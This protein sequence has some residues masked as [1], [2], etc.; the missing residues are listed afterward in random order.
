[1]SYLHASL[2]EGSLAVG[3]RVHPASSTARLAGPL[4]AAAVIL[5]LAQKPLRAH[6]GHEPLPTKGVSVQG[7]AIYLSPEASKALRLTFQEVDLADL[8]STVTA[9]ASVIVPWQQRAWVTTPT[10][11]RISKLYRRA[12]DQIDAG[13]VIAEVESLEL[14]NEQ[15]ELIQ[16]ALEL[17]LTEQTLERLGQLGDSGV[18]PERNVRSAKAMNAETT[19]AVEIGK[20]KLRAL[21]VTDEMLS[22]VLRSGEPIRRIPILAPVGGTIV[23][24][25]INPGQVV[26]PTQ[27]LFEILDLRR[28]YAEAWI[29]ESDVHRIQTGQTARF[30]MT[31][32]PDRAFEGTVDYVAMQA[33]GTSR[34]LKVWVALETVDA[35]NPLLRPGMFGSVQIVTD[36]AHDAIA[37]PASAFIR[38]GT[39]TVVF[40]EQAPGEY[41]RKPVVLGMRTPHLVEVVDGV[42][43]GDRV[44]LDGSR[45]LATFFEH[46]VLTV[47]PQAARNIGLELA[48][49]EYR[50][51]DRTIAIDGVVEVPPDRLA[52]AAPQVLG[53]VTRIW[54]YVAESVEPGQRLAELESLELQELQ[55]DL[56]QTQSRLR[57]AEQL[58]DAGRGAGSGVAQQQVLQ[59]RSEH[60]K[61]QNQLAGLQEKLGML[62]VA[63]A[64][65][66][67]VLDTGE[68]VASLPIRAPIGGFVVSVNVVAGQVVNAGDPMF[69]IHDLSK[70]WIRGHVFQ[71]EIPQVKLGQEVRVRLM[72]DPQYIATATLL[73]SNQ[74]LAG[75]GRVLAVWA[76][77]DNADVRLKDNMLARM[78]VLTATHPPTLA[79]P[80]TAVLQDGRDAYAFV[81]RHDE[82]GRFDRRALQTGARDDRFVA[83]KSGISEGE[84]VAIA[85]VHELQTAYA[86]I[87]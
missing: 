67:R 72:S 48:P 9:T 53:K 84:M 63:P 79:L 15:L 17:D 65:V 86:T 77:V 75:T 38:S 30:T 59:R 22:A 81:Q 85:G 64:D 20:R 87:K 11:G 66:Q 50:Q 34:S 55:L 52:I 42:Y 74:V 29:V 23:H 36:R 1:M 51:I 57:I 47:T 21:G 56:L 82:P 33:D 8:E 40:V 24:G 45:Q 19:V 83:I 14:V 68:I 7:N 12:G 61:L 46:G 44:V 73:R 62:G 71:A 78:T 76:A 41:L 26:A 43:P 69:E 25:D 4:A 58:L 27:H 2:N 54:V 35:D 32:V 28:V 5:V 60:R 3:I 80:L 16:N 37:C 18:V 10:G 31:A 49:A 6:E 70:L 13:A 39:D